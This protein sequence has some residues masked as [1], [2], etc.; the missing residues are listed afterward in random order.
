MEF[1]IVTHMMTER[2]MVEVWQ[3]GKFVASIYGH[4]DGVKIVSKYLDGVEPE[5][6]YPPAVVVH[7]SKV[8]AADEG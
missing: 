4:D 6:G 7:L 5:P 8:E 1:R 3:D 2:P